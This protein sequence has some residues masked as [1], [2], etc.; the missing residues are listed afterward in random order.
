MRRARGYLAG[1]MARAV[2]GLG[3]SSVFIVMGT[4]IKKRFIDYIIS[5]IIIYNA[6]SPGWDSI[7]FH[8][9]LNIAITINR[10]SQ[11]ELVV[12]QMKL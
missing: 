12:P 8:S 9:H 5:F 3:I 1:R 6:D 11:C 2:L 7:R 10:I 4:I